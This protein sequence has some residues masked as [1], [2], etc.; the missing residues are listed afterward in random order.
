M[1]GGRFGT[2]ENAAI[3]AH[4]GTITWL[5]P[6]AELPGSPQSLAHQV[7]DLQQRWLSP[8][9]IDC[10][11][12][13]VYAG[14]R[15]HEFEQRLSGMTYEDIAAAGGGILATVAATRAASEEKLFHLSAARVRQM[16]AEGVTVVEIKSGYGLDVENEL[17]LLRVARRLGATLPITVKT[18]L[19]AAH[20]AP[21]EYRHD[22][23]AYIDVVC[24]TIMPQAAAAGLVDAVDVFCD[25]VGFS[26]Q[27]SDKVFQAATALDLPVKIHAEQLSNQQGTQL[28]AHYNALSADHLEYLDQA[29]AKALANN[30]TVAVLLPGAYYYLQGDRKPPIDLLRYYNI[31]MAIAT[32]CNPGS[33]PTTSLQLMLSM[34]CCIFGL[35]PEEALAGVTLQAA[36]AL[37]LGDSHG[38]LEVGKKA[39]FAIWDIEQPTDLMAEFGN[40]RCYGRYLP[41][42]D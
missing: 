17:K 33:S 30:G 39:N 8:G 2:I 22:L 5:G 9:L 11:T 1:V 32:D 25:T 37:G 18:T 42:S 10:H 14:N 40:N 4:N 26:L 7:I 34:G 3:A 28:A 13:L 15:S 36:K 20:T 38:S 21:P 6:Q 31:P 41:N 23:D 12:H 16:I 19:L 27:Q 35:T 29:G 24:E